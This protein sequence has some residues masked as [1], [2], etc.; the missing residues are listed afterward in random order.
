MDTPQ[1]TDPQVILEIGTYN[2]KCLFCN[3]DCDMNEKTHQT[4][5][6][7]SQAIREQPG[8]GMEYT[9]VTTGYPHLAAAVKK[10][11]PDLEYIGPEEMY[12]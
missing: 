5:L 6:G 1:V 11:R 4:N 8:C 12:P 10:M 2:S 9:H 7:Y 3:R